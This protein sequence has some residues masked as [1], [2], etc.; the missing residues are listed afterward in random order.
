M[1]NALLILF[2]LSFSLPDR[3]IAQS[4]NDMRDVLNTLLESI[5]SQY[6]KNKANTEV[7]LSPFLVEV[8]SL[9]PPPGSKYYPYLYMTLEKYGHSEDSL[10]AKQ[11]KTFEPIDISTLATSKKYVIL[12]NYLPERADLTP[13]VEQLFSKIYL[14]TPFFFGQNKYCVIQVGSSG[15]GRMYLL[16]KENSKWSVKE[17]IISWTED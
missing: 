15:G 14:T 5:S 3:G 17:W 1:K 16:V 4:N 13:H 9:T 8:I 12:S 10:L 7:R 2:V 11:A 6:D